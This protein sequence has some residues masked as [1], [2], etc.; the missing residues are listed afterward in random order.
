MRGGVHWG[1][2]ESQ[3]INP[4]FEH[5]GSLVGLIGVGREG[6]GATIN[7]ERGGGEQRLK[8]P[9]CPP[10]PEIGGGEGE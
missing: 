2:C 3:I 5:W 10:G 8:S 1:A 7:E 6:R 4:L 9:P